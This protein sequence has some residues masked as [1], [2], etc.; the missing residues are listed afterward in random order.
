MVENEIPVKGQSDML[1]S[2][3]AGVLMRCVPIQGRLCV[4]ITGSGGKTSTME[5]LAGYFSRQGR[6]VLCS[7]TTRLAHPDLHSYPCSRQELTGG[8]AILALVPQAGEIVLFGRA[9]G[10]KLEAPDEQ[11]L[12]EASLGYDVVLIEGDGARSLPLKIHSGRDPVV[13]SWTG[14]AIAVIG[15]K[16]LGQPLDETCFYLSRRYRQLTGDGSTTVGPA[17][18]RRL[19]EHPEGLLKGIDD[20]PVVLFCNQSDTCTP[21]QVTAVRDALVAQWSGRPFFLIM[22]SVQQDSVECAGAVQAPQT[23]LGGALYED[24]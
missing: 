20:R 10:Q 24:F 9:D 22:G 14:V 7:T 13:P 23:P 19:L 12:R 1:V 11:M 21:K 6:R 18:Y 16:A 15:L 2:L 17:V 8:R 3:L 5:T 4:T